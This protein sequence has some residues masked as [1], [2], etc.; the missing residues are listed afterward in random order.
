MPIYHDC[1]AERKNKKRTSN[2]LSSQH[3]FMSR[4]PSHSTNNPLAP[5]LLLPPTAL[6]AQ[7]RPRTRPS[8]R[9][10]P[11]TTHTRALFA[12]ASRTA[13]PPALAAQRLQ[14]GVYRSRQGVMRVRRVVGFP[15]DLCALVLGSEAGD[16][17]EEVEAGLG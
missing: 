5:P 2:T 7:T 1:F 12:L 8:T 15:V 3:N 14:T 11:T 4:K 13:L 6:S 16:E 17:R 9:T 10:T